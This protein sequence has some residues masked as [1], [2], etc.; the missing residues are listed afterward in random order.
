MQFHRI[1]QGNILRVWDKVF[2]IHKKKKQ[3]QKQNQ[4]QSRP[5]KIDRLIHASSWTM[6]VNPDELYKQ[7]MYS[8]LADPY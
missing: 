4:K 1:T 2:K 8:L 5:N 3:K 6:A 7:Q